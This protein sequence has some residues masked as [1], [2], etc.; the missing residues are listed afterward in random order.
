MAHFS[1]KDFFLK[2]AKVYGADI[3]KVKRA[4]R[5]AG[6]SNFKRNWDHDFLEFGV[7][8]IPALKDLAVEVGISSSVMETREDGQYLRELKVDLTYPEI[9]DPA[10]DV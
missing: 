8:A 2:S 10:L 1:N 5:Q 3:L 7:D 9:F 4:L 6:Y